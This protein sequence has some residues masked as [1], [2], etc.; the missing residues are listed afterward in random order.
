[1]M[2]RKLI[3]IKYNSI[4]KLALER[5]AEF[6]DKRIRESKSIIATKIFKKKLYRNL[7]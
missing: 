1:M 3:Y 4:Q 7:K 6:I 5:L 2:K